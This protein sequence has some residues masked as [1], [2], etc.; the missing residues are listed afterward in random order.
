[1]SFCNVTRRLRAPLVVASVLLPCGVIAAESNHVLTLAEAEQLAVALDPV[2]S[3]LYAQSDALLERAV[4][5][6]QLPDPELSVGLAEVPLDNFDLG[7]HEDTEV[8]LGLSQSF[9]P[10]RTRRYMAERM[11]AMADAEKAGA[12][13]QRLQVAREVRSAYVTLYYELETRRVL[14]LNRKLFEEMADTTEREYAEGRDN[15]HDVLRAQLELSL[16]EDRIEQARGEI[17]V[18]RAELTKWVG[19]DHGTRALATDEPPVPEPGDLN[20]LRAQLARHPLL[21][22]D[23]AAIEAAR[24]SIGVAEQQYKPQWMIDFMLTENTADAFDQ[25]GGPDFAGVFLRMSLPIFTDKRQDRRLAASRLEATAAQFSRADRLRELTR[26]AEADQAQAAT[27][28]AY[29]NDLADFET[30][31]R[32]RALALETE[33]QLIRLRAEAQ[34]SRARLLYLSGEPS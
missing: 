14:E 22:M 33:L 3:Q 16:V 32:A 25:R 13:N 10:G 21:A 28:N 7:E 30:L 20:A 26:Q 19:P 27:F 24:K 18:A 23:D 6:G 11:V 4:A 31:V 5:E 8:R 1:M 29:Q 9:P 12:L 15:Q 2:I 34:R 17:D